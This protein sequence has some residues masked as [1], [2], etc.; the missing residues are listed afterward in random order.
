MESFVL[1]TDPSGAHFLTDVTA[2]P[3]SE[4]Q[5]FSTVPVA[6]AD[7]AS[8]FDWA[9]ASAWDAQAADGIDRQVWLVMGGVV[10]DYF[11][12]RP[13]VSLSPAPKAGA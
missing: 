6:L 4:T 7:H 8:A 11:D 10:T 1:V 3:T 12:T 2:T 5:R 9:A 13:V